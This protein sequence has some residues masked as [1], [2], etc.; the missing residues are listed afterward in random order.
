[1]CI[2]PKSDFLKK[3]YILIILINFIRVYHGFFGYPNLDP[4]C[5]K[6]IRQDP[7]GNTAELK[8][9]FQPFLY[10]CPGLHDA[11]LRGVLEVVGVEDG[12]QQR[13]LLW[14]ELGTS[15]LKQLCR[16]VKSK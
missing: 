14:G 13:L 12:P 11:H 16:E 15:L 9:M 3:N 8:T 2:K 5:L 1:M 6:W 10:F 7:V 4:R